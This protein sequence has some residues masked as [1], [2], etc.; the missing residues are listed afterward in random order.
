MGYPPL[1]LKSIARCYT[2]LVDKPI[3][4]LVR[5]PPALLAALRRWAERN[6]RSVTA[7]IVYRL[8]R[9]IRDDERK[10]DR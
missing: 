3:K 10:A 8:E 5:F 1:S 2:L 4:F 7:E 9:S 6:H